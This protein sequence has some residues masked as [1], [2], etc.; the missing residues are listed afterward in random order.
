M[1]ISSLHYILV[2]VPMTW[3]EIRLGQGLKC[4]K[5]QPLTQAPM[6]FMPLCLRNCEIIMHRSFQVLHDYFKF[7]LYPC[8]CIHDLVRNM[9]WSGAQMHQGW[10][11]DASAFVCHA[12]VPEKLW[13]N[14]AL[15]IS[16]FAWLFQVCTISLSVY[17]W[18]GDKYGL[19]RS[20]NASRMSTWCKRLCVSCLS[21]WE[22]V[23]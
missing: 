13:N 12:S 10:A 11:P 20:S 23:K 8:Q 4:I 17:P 19:V 16:S 15:D 2:S 21:A 9:A 5:D 1:I 22:I 18:L 3:W 6:W 7:A 14:H